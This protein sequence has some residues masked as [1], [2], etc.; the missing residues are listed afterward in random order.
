M[1]VHRKV[2]EKY[3][4]LFVSQKFAFNA[5]VPCDPVNSETV[6]NQKL[7]FTMQNQRVPIIITKSNGKIF[8][9]LETRSGSWLRL[10]SD[11]VADITATPSNG[12]WLT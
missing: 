6:T 1:R 5:W 9:Y 11:A 12:L 8:L 2:S 10:A 7:T 4:H 3:V